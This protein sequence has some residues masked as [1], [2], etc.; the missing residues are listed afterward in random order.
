[1]RRS[2]AER[3]RLPQAARRVSGGANQYKTE[4]VFWVP[5]EVLKM[6][7]SH[8][9]ELLALSGP[10]KAYPGK[11]GVVEEGALADLLLVHGDP[12]ANLIIA[13]AEKNLVLVMKEGAIYENSIK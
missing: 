8:N 6:V 10:R 12:I 13:D 2:R 4:N 7:T 9:A 1:M 5:A 11:L 3:D